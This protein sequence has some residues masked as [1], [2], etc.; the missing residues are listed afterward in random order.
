MLLALI[1]GAVVLVL[2]VLVAVGYA[3]SRRGAAQRPDAPPPPTPAITAAAP[4]QKP[5]EAQVRQ[6]FVDGGW[7]AG[8]NY[9]HIKTITWNG[10]IL[11]F[12]TDL[13]PKAENKP[14]AMW[15]C[16]L[17]AQYLEDQKRSPDVQVKDSQGGVLASRHA[18]DDRCAW[19]R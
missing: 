12:T 7:D 13:Y 18:L 17:G 14:P 5:A 9:G 3:A 1:A 16:N 15:I 6:W 2:G 19:R 10:D 11:V 4:A 8:S